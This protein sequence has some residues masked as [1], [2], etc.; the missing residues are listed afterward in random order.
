M[1]RP[2]RYC[3]LIATAL[4][5]GCKQA[6]PGDVAAPDVP[7][8]TQVVL[9]HPVKR[10]LADSVEMNGVTTYT[11]RENIRAT[12]TGYVDRSGVQ[13]GS[14]VTTGQELFV[15]QTR[16]AAI[17][18]EELLRDSSLNIT[19]IVPVV[20]RNTG[21]V[22]QLFYLVGDFVME[23]DILAEL[24]R[25]DALAIKLYVPA[26]RGR[27]VRAGNRVRVKL[28]DGRL[29]A[30]SVGRLLPSE[31]VNSQTAPYLV[32]LNTSIYLPE[33]LNLMVSVPDRV[34]RDALTVPASA[35]QANEVQ[36]DFWVMQLINDSLAVRVA[37]RPGMR[38]DSTIEILDS[39]LTVDDR[40]VVTGA[41]GLEDSSLVKAVPHL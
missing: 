29:L 38:S 28:P 3:M 40:I 39:P 17:L 22:T 14:P 26:E 5:G 27:L 10:T 2:F 21:I 8:A 35:V 12:V 41:Y 7:Q 9:G 24:T 11:N 33:N 36:T 23:G 32:S 25:P 13:V 30:G 34:S 37:V 16:E 15:L 1:S 4:V 19:G 6:A 31:D 18:G 20:S